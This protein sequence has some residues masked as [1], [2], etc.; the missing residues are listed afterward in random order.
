VGL[1]FTW[2]VAPVEI[3][4]SRPDFLHPE[5]KLVY[6]A[7][8]GDIYAYEQDLALAE[9][10]LAELDI[11]ADGEVLAGLIEQYLDGGGRPEEVRNLARLAEA[12]GASG[13]V[14]SVFAAVPTAQPV[15][16]A[17][18]PPQPGASPTPVP[19]ITPAPT[20]RL[21]ERTAVCAEPGQQGQIAIRVQDTDG[22]E[23]AGIEIVVSWATGQDRFFTGLWPEKGDGYADFSMSRGIEYDVTLA[24]F[25]GDVAQGLT[26]ALAPGTCPTGT[27]A[28][29]WRLVFAEAP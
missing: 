10:R 4:D 26:S 5:D 22:G 16:A 8:I 18:T 24:A 9:T 13:G 12:L 19:S 29:D 3:G 15:A 6:L 28:L 2:V 21:V 17:T 1:I 11:T 25:K 23:L 20:F 14:L 7:L 27:V